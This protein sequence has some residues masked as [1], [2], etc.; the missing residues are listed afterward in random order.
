MITCPNCQHKFSLQDALCEDWQDENKKLG[1]P[2][3]KRFLRPVTPQVAHKPMSTKRKI[4]SLA[5][6]AIWIAILA[7]RD[8]FRSEPNI[9]HSIAVIAV[10]IAAYTYFV[11]KHR[12]KHSPYEVV[13]EN[14]PTKDKAQ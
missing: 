5:V 7:I 12:P 6:F 13:P 1:C 10:F 14:E 11:I 4:L 3:C 2:S 8:E 9:W